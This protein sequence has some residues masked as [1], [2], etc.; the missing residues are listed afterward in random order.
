MALVDGWGFGGDC[1]F[2]LAIAL[3]LA[4]AARCWAGSKISG[5]FNASKACCF[6]ACALHAAQIVFKTS[7]PRDD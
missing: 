3:A 6:V 7:T 4:M 2:V 5:A 1:V